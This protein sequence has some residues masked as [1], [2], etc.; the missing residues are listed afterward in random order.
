MLRRIKILKLPHEE[1]V[2]YLVAHKFIVIVTTNIE[3]ATIYDDDREFDEAYNR[4][5]K[6]FGKKHKVL[7]EIVR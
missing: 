3:E 4:A 2:K 7:A 5:I 6:V 1:E